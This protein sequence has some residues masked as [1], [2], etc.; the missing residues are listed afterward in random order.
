MPWLGPLGQLDFHHF[1]LVI[2]GLFGKL[3]GIKAAVFLA[4]AKIAAADL[5]VEIP[6]GLAVVF[7]DAA[8]AGAVVKIAS[9]G[10]GVQRQH[11]IGPQGTETHGGNVEH[12]CRVGLAA[13]GAADGH[14]R[15]LFGY[16]PGGQGMVEPLIIGLIDVHFGTEGLLGLDALGALVHERTPV[17]VKGRPVLVAFDKVLVNRRPQRLQDKPHAP[18]DG[19]VAQQAVLG[20][21]II[22]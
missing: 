14:P 17:P 4:A 5:P 15:L 10:A 3:V 20:L 12:R 11:G 21:G 18:H 19:I 6:A 13:L 9:F 8:F 7:T 1:D 22:V 16:R 2:L